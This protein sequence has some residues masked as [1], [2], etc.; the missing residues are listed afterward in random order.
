MSSLHKQVEELFSEE[1]PSYCNWS[2]TIKFLY[3]N[4]DKLDNNIR[5]LLIKRIED[6]RLYFSLKDNLIRR[7]DISPNVYKTNLH[8][9]APTQDVVE[10]NE[11]SQATVSLAI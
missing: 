4:E 3:D 2:H 8:L 5:I 11:L 7:E 10:E 9:L 1:R 6:Y